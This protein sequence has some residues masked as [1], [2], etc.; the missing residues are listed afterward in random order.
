LLFFELDQLI[1]EGKDKKGKKKKKDTVPKD[2]KGTVA[3]M[4]QKHSDKFD[5]ECKDPDKLGPYAV[6]NAMKNKGHKSHYKP[7]EDTDKKPEKKEKYKNEATY[8]TFQEW[9]E[10]K[11]TGTTSTA[12]V[13]GYQRPIGGANLGVGEE[14]PFFKKK[15]T[16]PS[17]LIRRGDLTKLD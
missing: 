3:A 8:P 15:R 13:A 6:A 7:Q 1:T 4:K 14:D 12:C 16:R 9:I 5:P 10:L 2:M 17:H 11:E